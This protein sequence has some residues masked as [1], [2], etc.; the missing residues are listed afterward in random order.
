VAQRLVGW[1]IRRVFTHL[2][3]V[4]RASLGG[5]QVMVDEGIAPSPPLSNHL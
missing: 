1:F 3:K 4:L 5:A 2:H